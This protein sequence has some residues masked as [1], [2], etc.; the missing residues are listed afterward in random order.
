MKYNVTVRVSF[1]VFLSSNADTEEDAVK[2]A[3]TRLE[4]MSNEDI[5]MLSDPSGYMFTADDAYVSEDED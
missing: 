2:D 3:I 1:D 5:A 4:N